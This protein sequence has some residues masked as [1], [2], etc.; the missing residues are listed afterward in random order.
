M[1]IVETRLIASLL[2]KQQPPE[3]LGAVKI[4]QRGFDRIPRKEMRTLQTV[5]TLEKI[6][7]NRLSV[8]RG[9]RVHEIG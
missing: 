1:L 9:Y 3:T 7:R 8:K 6:G 2:V 5:A 4:G